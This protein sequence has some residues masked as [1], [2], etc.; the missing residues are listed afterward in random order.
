MKHS[1]II[2]AL[3]LATTFSVAQSVWNEAYYKQYSYQTI[4]NFGPINDTIVPEKI[5]YK[6]LNAAIF[7]ET[8]RQRALNGLPV[9]KHNKLL[10]NSAQGHSQDMVT[11]NFFSHTSTVPGKC[12][13]IDRTKREGISETYIG[14]NVQYTYMLKLNGAPYYSPSQVGC[15]KRLSGEIIFMHTYRTLAIEIVN[16]WM[17]SPGHRENILNSNYTHIGVGDC[18]YYSGFGIDR[19]PWVKSTQ[20][21]AKLNDPVIVT[22]KPTY[23]SY[24]QY[25]QPYTYSQPSKYENHKYETITPKKKPSQIGIGVSVAGIF[26]SFGGLRSGKMD[27]QLSGQLGG[28]IGEKGHGR[29]FW[30]V[31]PSVDLIDGYPFALECG[32]VLSRFLKFSAGARMLPDGK[33]NLLDYTVVPSATVGIQLHLWILFVSLDCNGFYRNGQ[34]EQRF[35]ASAGI[36]F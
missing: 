16:N 32:T 9:F 4:A 35:I 8:N 15:F 28:Y 33:T 19:I 25:S 5:D 10:E 7:F 24:N 22:R 12:N 31:F 1:I 14:E 2:F 34:A 20:N 27:Y 11:Y 21:F 17:N 36:C 23:S 30:G 29:S 18:I 6:L 13:P 26:D 3:L